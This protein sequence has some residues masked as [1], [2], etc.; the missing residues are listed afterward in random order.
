MA[1]REGVG[2]IE[3]LFV[4]ARVSHVPIDIGKDTMTAPRSFTLSARPSKRMTGIQIR[5]PKLKGNVD[6]RGGNK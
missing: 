5:R 3:R 2:D 6:Q 1:Y 4:F